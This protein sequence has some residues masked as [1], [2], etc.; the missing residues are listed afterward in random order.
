[1]NELAADFVCGMRGLRRKLRAISAQTFASKQK[2]IAAL[3]WPTIKA[4]S[5]R[6]ELISSSLDRSLNGPPQNLALLEQW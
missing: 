1:M 5:G 2:Y 6:A 4:P 3:V